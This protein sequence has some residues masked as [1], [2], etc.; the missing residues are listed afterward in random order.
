MNKKD[1]IVRRISLILIFLVIIVFI[2]IKAQ[3]YLREATEG[4]INLVIN[5]NN[6]TERLKHEVKIENGIIY[7]LFCSFVV[8]LVFCFIIL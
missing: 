7:Y 8:L 3:N 2:L 4:E 1:N 5:N 6:V